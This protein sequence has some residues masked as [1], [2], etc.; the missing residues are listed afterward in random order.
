MTCKLMDG[1]IHD[2]FFLIEKRKK[3]KRETVLRNA[4]LVFYKYNLE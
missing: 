3:E 1:H 2:A 4:F